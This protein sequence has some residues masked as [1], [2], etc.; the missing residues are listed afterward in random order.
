[1]ADEVNEGLLVIFELQGVKVHKI[2]RVFWSEWQVGNII[3]L[4]L[5]IIKSEKFL[6]IF[7]KIF[8]EIFLEISIGDMRYVVHRIKSKIEVLLET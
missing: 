2:R 4:G 1:M 8:L 6:E 3:F 5:G 7:L